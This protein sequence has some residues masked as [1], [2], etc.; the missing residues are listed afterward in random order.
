MSRSIEK[1]FL[2]ITIA[3]GSIVPIGGGLLGIAEGTSMLGHGG[4]SDLDSHVRYLSGLLLGIGVAFLSLIPDI[5]MQS[6]KITLLCSIVVV[7]G[8]ARFY[9]IALDGAP[10]PTMASALIMEL[11]V[12]PIVWLWQ[13][14]LTRLLS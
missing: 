14:R 11:G 13:Q 6:A 3:I 8:L 7:G 12:V 1:R 9:G 4:N 5:E 2:Q 10:S